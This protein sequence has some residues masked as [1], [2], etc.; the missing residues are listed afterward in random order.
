[1]LSHSLTVTRRLAVLRCK[2]DTTTNTASRVGHYPQ[3]TLQ[4]S[5]HH[6]YVCAVPQQTAV[7][8]TVVLSKPLTLQYATY[9][10]GHRISVSGITLNKD[11]L[12]FLPRSLDRR[13]KH[14]RFLGYDSHLQLLSGIFL[15]SLNEKKLGQHQWKMIWVLCIY[16][17][18]LYH[19]WHSTL[20]FSVSLSNSLRLH[21][22][23]L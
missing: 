18:L 2:I 3:T 1:M 11:W 13:P 5:C 14:W 20:K 7:L 22:R 12:Q 10:L 9:V 21:L 4:D 6:R 17:T 19:F 23:E 15:W 16:W 8:Q